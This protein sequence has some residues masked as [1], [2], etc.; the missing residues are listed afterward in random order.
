GCSTTFDGWY[1]RLF[2]G[3]SD[4]KWKNDHIVA[5]VH[6]TPTDEEGNP[7]GWVLHAGTGPVNMLVVTTELP[8]GRTMAFVGPVLSYYEHVTAGFKR[9]TDEEWKTLYAVS[10]SFRPP[11]VNI[12]LADAQGGSR[13]LGPS[14]VTGI[15]TDPADGQQP[16]TVALEQNFP[17]PFNGQTVISFTIPHLLSG[18]P[19]DLV[20]YDVQGRRMRTLLHQRMPAGTFLA[21]WTG[22]SESGAQAASGVYFYQLRLGPQVRTGKMAL[23]R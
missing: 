22:D 10:P 23:I 3:H 13:G 16:K 7:V 8:D 5:D 6:T 19:V 15:N 12:Y 1:I 14:L 17:N 18:S 20:I 2:Y 11:L 4:G 21:R 9:L